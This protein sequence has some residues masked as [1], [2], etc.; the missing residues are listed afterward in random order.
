MPVVKFSLSVSPEL[1]SAI[2]RASATSRVSVSRQVETTLRESKLIAKFIQEV[3]QEPD[4]SL[5]AVTPSTL[6]KMIPAHRANSRKRE[7]VVPTKL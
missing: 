4:G 2:V 6:R 7:S 1:Y 3:R 5:L